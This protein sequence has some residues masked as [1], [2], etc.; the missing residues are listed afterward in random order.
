MN[1]D[2]PE[3][4]NPSR[5][6]NKME[7]IRQ[8]R[9]SGVEDDH[10]QNALFHSSVQMERVHKQGQVYR[11]CPARSLYRTNQPCSEVHSSEALVVKLMLLG[12]KLVDTGSDGRK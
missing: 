1:A 5:E 4:S 2:R 12:N 10:T 7:L 6:G 11:S 8:K 9:I 3:G